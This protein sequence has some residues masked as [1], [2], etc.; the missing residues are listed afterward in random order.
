R[1]TS[2]LLIIFLALLPGVTS[3]MGIRNTRTLLARSPDGAHALYE[4]R[5][6]GPEGGGSLGYR[7][8]G[9]RR[10]DT[11]D[12]PVS[13]TFSP[14]DGSRPPLRRPRRRRR[15]SA[16][17]RRGSD[18]VRALRATSPLPPRRAGACRR[19]RPRCRRRR[20]RFGAHAWSGRRPCREG[21]R[22]RDPP[23]ILPPV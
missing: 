9:R 7:L 3:A 16:R 13:S 12:Y 1:N 11:A 6:H 20:H 18:R 21:Y 19:T 23:A 22:E 2:K 5:G 4:I 17:D 15:L 14:G 8:E 10:D